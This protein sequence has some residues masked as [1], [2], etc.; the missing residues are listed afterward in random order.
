MHEDK[1]GVQQETVKEAPAQKRREHTPLI[2]ISKRDVLPWQKAWLIRGGAILLSMV[3]MG[4]VSLMLTGENPFVIYGTLFTGNFGY[5]GRIWTL[6]FNTAI[7]LGIA[8]ALTP[9]FRMR[10]WNIGAEGQVLFGGLLSVLVMI[11]MGKM[12]NSWPNAIVLLMMLLVGVIGGAIWGLI[13]AIFKAIWGTNETLFTL[14]MNYVA[15]GLVAFSIQ[16][17]FPKG[18]GTMGVVNSSSYL[19]WLPKIGTNNYLLTILIVL[20]MTVLMYIYLRYSKQG[21]EIS[22]VGES[23]NTARYVGINVKKV[24]LRTMAISGAI[25][26]LIGFLLVSGYNHSISTDAVGGRGFTAIMVCWLAK[27]NPI[28]MFLTSFLICFLEQGA[29]EVA[30]KCGISAA[31]ADIL[32][33]I[34]LF[35]I[36]GCE[37]FIQYRVRFNCSK[38]EAA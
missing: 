25:C 38:K 15:T 36:I 13:P 11:G 27:F 29:A 9:A 26:G 3:F 14:M 5:L 10:F 19:G 21:Y 24:I 4:I 12:E 37:F 17:L 6:L 7:L 2:H 31:Y 23:E 1:Q 30:S 8:L 22:V 35:F 34:V 18:T 16:A 28:F 20:V 33:G 32:V